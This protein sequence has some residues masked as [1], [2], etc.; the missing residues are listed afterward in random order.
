MRLPL[1]HPA[2]FFVRSTAADRVCAGD[3]T[4]WAALESRALEPNAYLSPH[5]VRPAARHLAGSRM[6]QVYFVERRS[7]G[8]R[9]LVGVA[10][11][12]VAAPG[13]G[14]PARRLVGFRTHY[15]PVGGLLLDREFPL[16][17]LD[18]LLRHLRAAG[19]HPGAVQLPLIWR[20][21]PL[22]TLARAAA[23]EVGFDIGL[24]EAT[25]RAVLVPTNARTQLESKALAHRLRDLG[26]RRRRLEER[27]AIGWRLHRDA[28]IPESAI[29]ALLV[30]EHMGWKGS[31]GTSLRSAP[32]RE[33]FFREMV[34]GFAA[35]R[36][37]IF[38]EL[39]LEGTPIATT[40]NFISGRSGFAFK[41]GWNPELR[42]YS[43]GWLN[44]LEFM[45]A[46]GERL[47]DVDFMDSGATVDSYINE[48]W[49]ER[50]TLATLTIPLS[51]TGRLALS[52]ISSARRL[53]RGMAGAATWVSAI[54]TRRRHTLASAR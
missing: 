34:A 42:G 41:I 38:S 39:T 12:L 22:P 5:F 50:R 18:A 4:A 48:L 25:P 20:D 23:G 30:L 35:E 6:P 51:L 40:C 17:T 28:G 44:E 33:A 19:M 21:G 9:E 2:Q 45:R 13:L 10:V 36:R 14:F 15:S 46:A 27:G 3:V 47:V 16:E 24:A 7:S 37:A 1:S 8:M 53:K 26:R 29:E 32:A 52:G 31:G 11:L 49:L 43:P 54:V